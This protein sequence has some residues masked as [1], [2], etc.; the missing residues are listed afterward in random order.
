MP[1]DRLNYAQIRED[2]GMPETQEWRWRWDTKD[3]ELARKLY[4]D[5]FSIR[6]VADIMCCSTT[7]VQKAIKRET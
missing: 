1:E 6:E 7:H 4:A 2:Y 5:N 3:F